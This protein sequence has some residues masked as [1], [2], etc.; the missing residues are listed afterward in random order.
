MNENTLGDLIRKAQ[1]NRTQNYF[2]ELC[3]LSSASITRICAGTYVP[4]PPILQKIAS[5]AQNGVTYSD[6]MIT[7]GF[8]GEMPEG[9][10]SSIS[11]FYEDLQ[12][13]GFSIENYNSLT[14]DEKQN[15]AKTVSSLAIG[16]SLNKNK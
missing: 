12:K 13:A 16:L 8:I 10:P 6:L 15:F 3:G 5:H 9:F 1:G 4:K 11:K 14:E 7:A 2:A